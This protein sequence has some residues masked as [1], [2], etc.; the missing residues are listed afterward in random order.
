MI[1]HFT[2]GYLS[3]GNAITT[4]KRYLHLHV[5]FSIIDN[6]KDIETTRVHREIDK[7]HV[8]GTHTHTHTH[9]HTLLFSHKKGVNLAIWD[10]ID[11]PCRH[12]AK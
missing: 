12:N 6:C 4:L 11:V 7:G 5:H 2:S 9:T 10:N 3:K 8:L 1:L